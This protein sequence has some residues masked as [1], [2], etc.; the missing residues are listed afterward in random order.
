MKPEAGR[1]DQGCDEGADQENGHVVRM[2]RAHLLTYEKTDESGRCDESHCRDI[3]AEEAA[4]TGIRR[5]DQHEY[6]PP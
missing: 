5:R 1:G 2:A 4:E 3:P 6:P